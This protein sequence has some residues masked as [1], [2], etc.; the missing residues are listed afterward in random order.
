MQKTRV[1]LIGCLLCVVLAALT[2]CDNRS[3]DV[4]VGVGRSQVSAENRLDRQTQSG[5]PPGCA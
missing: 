1:V 4:P 3:K 2:G 5:N